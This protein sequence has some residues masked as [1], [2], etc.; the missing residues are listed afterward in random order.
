MLRDNGFDK[1]AIHQDLAHEAQHS[2]YQPIFACEN[3]L[4]GDALYE[5]LGI[6]PNA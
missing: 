5:S 1:L 4:T 3:F 2:F 6:I